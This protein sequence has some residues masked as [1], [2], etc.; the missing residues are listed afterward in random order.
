MGT[1]S[2]S[3]IADIIRT[4]AAERPD[5]VALETGGRSVTFGELDRRSNQV[6]HALEAAG[7]GTGDR[8]A[9][10]EKNGLEF[11]EVTFALAKLGAVNV[12]VNWRLAPAE[13]LQ[14]I[15]DAQSEVLIV[16][17][18]FVGHIEQIEDQLTRVQTMV[19]IGDHERWITYESWVADQPDDDHGVGVGGSDVAFQ[20]YTSGTTGLPKGVMLTN[21]NFFQ[22]VT[23]VAAQWRFDETS[24]NLAMMPMFHIAGAG[25]GMVG[26]Y[27]GCRTVVMRDIDPPAILRAIPEFGITN[28]FMVPV[29]IQFLLITP[30]VDETDFSSLK[31]LVYGA[32]P[33]TDD[34]LVKGIETF[35]CEF[36]Q[37]YGLTE[38]TGAITQLDGVDHDPEGRPHLLR[39]CGRPYPWV[40]L[41]VIDPDSGEDVTV[42]RVG[43]LWTR[44]TQN[45]AGY[46]NNP[47]ATAQAVTGDGWFK[48]GD[49]GYLDPEGFVFL[50]DRVKD[51]IVTGGENVYPAEVENALMKS[52]LVADV[53]VIGVPDE[54]WGEAVKAI[55]VLAEGAAATEAELI[56]FAREHLAGFKLPKSVDVA[57]TLP[58]NPSGKLLKRELREP[59]WEGVDRRVG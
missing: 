39:S 16:G 30:G 15:D 37:V 52:P 57:E 6:A 24:V 38:T 33:I 49:A 8:V 42:G 35:G 32:S 14:I 40:E 12:A 59:Y 51:M 36:I 54:R 25:W 53:A 55:V 27:F 10:I 21:D 47:E 50:H 28:A 44:S 58:R 13:M 29:V 22:C 3:T 23:G 1:E 4:H 26:L 9:F 11:F 31:T 43:E 41:R 46:W 34:V 56:A 17:P 19:S 20:L 7:V 5:A 18:D 2:I 45:M 48:T